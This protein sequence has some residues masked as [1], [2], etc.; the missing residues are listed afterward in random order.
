MILIES[1]AA[2]AFLD[3]IVNSVMLKLNITRCNDSRNPEWR[4]FSYHLLV[5]KLTTLLFSAIWPFDD[6]LRC[7]AIRRFNL[8]ARS[9]DNIPIEHFWNELGRRMRQRC[10]T[11]LSQ[12]ATAPSENHGKL[13]FIKAFC[14]IIL[15]MPPNDSPSYQNRFV[16]DISL[17]S[18]CFVIKFLCF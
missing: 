13:H 4:G 9:A 2:F 17:I 10:P 3:R 7:P 11:S 12:L 14:C 18:P 15:S 16:V 1:E 5:F 8:L 6:F